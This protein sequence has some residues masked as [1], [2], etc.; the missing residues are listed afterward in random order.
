M[1]TVEKLIEELKKYDQ[2][3]PLILTIPTQKGST[4]IKL[5]DKVETSSVTNPTDFAKKDVISILGE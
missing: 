5:I 1:F 3:M 2:K 4:V